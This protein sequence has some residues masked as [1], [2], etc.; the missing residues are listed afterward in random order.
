MIKL[1][2]KYYLIASLAWSCAEQNVIDGDVVE[3]S[4]IGEKT[5]LTA[6]SPKR[7]EFVDVAERV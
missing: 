3:V 5:P 1:L 7:T 2:V 4:R 6:E